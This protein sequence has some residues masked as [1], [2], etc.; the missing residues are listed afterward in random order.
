MLPQSEEGCEFRSVI[1]KLCL[2]IAILL[3]V[4][5]RL[6]WKLFTSWT[7][8]YCWCVYSYDLDISVHPASKKGVKYLIF[9]AQMST[10]MWQI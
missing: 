8:S 7:A 6:P 10:G 5:P 3:I 2:W 9:E 1:F 4:P